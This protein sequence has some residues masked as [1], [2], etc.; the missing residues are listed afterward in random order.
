MEPV[1]FRLVAQCLNQLRH[2]YPQYA[3]VSVIMHRHKVSEVGI[4]GRRLK[5]KKTHFFPSDC[6][7]GWSHCWRQQISQE[8]GKTAHNALCVVAH[9][10][11]TRCACTFRVS[12]VVTVHTRV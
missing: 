2:Q 8:K 4:H 7:H 10:V 9:R 12:Y 3:S 11:Y 1:T 5:K 6:F